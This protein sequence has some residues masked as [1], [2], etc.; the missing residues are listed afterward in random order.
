MRIATLTAAALALTVGVASATTFGIADRNDDGAISK[1]EF[2][3]VYGP[4]LDAF[5]FRLI[6]DND[7]GVIDAGEYAD[8]RSHTNGILKNAE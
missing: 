3:Q 7:D 5:S 8:A 1:G 2:V 6:D 4:E